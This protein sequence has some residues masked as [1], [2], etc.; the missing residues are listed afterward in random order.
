VLLMLVLLM[1]VILLVLH[2]L[3]REERADWR[4]DSECCHRILKY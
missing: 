4:E 2:L 1:L 3:L